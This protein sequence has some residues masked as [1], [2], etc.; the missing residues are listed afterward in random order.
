M[1][2]LV[3][4]F[5]PHVILHVGVWEPHARLATGA[6]QACTESVAR[7]V[8]DAAHAAN[9]LETVVVRSGTE[10]YG[11]HSYSPHI[12]VES[13]PIEPT[14]VYGRMCATIETQATDLRIAKGVNV[15]T[16]RLAP[17]LGA[18]VPSPLGRLLRM[19][20]VPYHGLYNP[21]FSVV[22]DHDAATAFMLGADRD[23]D[24]TANIV[25]NGAISMLRALTMGRRVP[26]PAFGPGWWLARNM[27]NAAG[28]PIPDHVSEL[29]EKGR[30]A[31]SNEA[32]HLLRFAPAH[33]T[34]QVID[35]LYTW[36]TV[37]RIPA[38]VQVA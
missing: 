23:A 2:E 3:A 21:A 10:I 33:T 1:S 19:P 25:A 6:A 7:A 28:A 13:T 31:A 20:V 16:L 26:A 17:V 36:P 11:S 12:A 18:H 22:E 9:S 38:K 34:T 37:E 14:T 15:C 24:G 32:A 29:L 5:D 35:R 8:F 30:Q 4:G 27:S